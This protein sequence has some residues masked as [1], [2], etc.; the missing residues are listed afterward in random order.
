MRAQLFVA[1]DKYGDVIAQLEA[2]GWTRFPHLSFPRFDL[3]WANYSKIMWKAVR[4]TQIVNHFQNAVLFS[5]KQQLTSALYAFDAGNSTAEDGSNGTITSQVDSF[6]PRTFTGS[7]VHELMRWVR[8]SQSLAVL[9]QFVAAAPLSTHTSS[10]TQ[11]L[12]IDMAIAH[13]RLVLEDQEFFSPQRR[14]AALH[15]TDT[16]R[17]PAPDL[18][19]QTE[20]DTE[21]A[22]DQRTACKRLLLILRA[23]DPQFDL[24]GPLNR[25]V[26]ICK[27]SNLS[28]GRGIQ[29]VSS[30]EALLDIIQPADCELKSDTREAAQWVVQKYIERPLLLQQARKFDLRQW[31]LITSL[32]PLR[33]YWYRQCYLRFCS[34]PFSLDEEKLRDRFTHLSNYSIQQHAP[35][36]DQGT[37]GAEAANASVSMMWNSNRFQDELR[38]MSFRA[39]HLCSVRLMRSLVCRQQHGRDVWTDTIVPRMKQA[40]RVAV[41]SVHP[42]LREIGVCIYPM[43]TAVYGVVPFVI[44]FMILARV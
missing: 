40:T 14:Q 8:Y 13:I 29:L 32:Q 17:A 41:A 23:S 1:D 35:A 37:E 20:S 36:E 22:I 3:K 42:K 15:G 21:T 11:Q 33:V 4:P 12:E 9:K 18:P 2:R 44:V 19:R 24:V 38:Y 31:V 34:Q 6:F 30:M 43:L 7:Q 25:N 27:P 26:W 5:Q 16:A 28:Q 10:G 39:H